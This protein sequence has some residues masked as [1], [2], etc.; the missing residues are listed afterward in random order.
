MTRY[1]NET[2]VSPEKSRSEIETT[3]TRYG[4]SSFAYGW[5]QETAVIGFVVN[6]RQIRFRLDL[7]DR[8]DRAITHT[9]KTRV[10][11]DARAIEAAFD[12]AVRQRWRA[13]ALVIKAKLEAVETG[14]TTF[15]DEFLAH[16][17]LPDGST[18]GEWMAPQ[19]DRAYASGEMPSMLPA[20]GTGER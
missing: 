20:L 19:I 14:I 9:P 7:P 6:G 15:E 10:R 8:N 4:A 13:L 11:R 3:L 17:V 12:Q 5:D 18:A 1:A 2:S 16:T